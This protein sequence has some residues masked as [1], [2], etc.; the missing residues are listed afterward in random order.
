MSPVRLLQQVAS[1]A[2]AH[3]GLRLIRIPTTTLA[4][5]DSG[6]GVKNSVN[7]FEKKN[8][9][10]SFAVPWGVINDR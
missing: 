4:Q 3:R 1:A 9:L 2:I 7:L 8:W 10:G 6:I 5:A